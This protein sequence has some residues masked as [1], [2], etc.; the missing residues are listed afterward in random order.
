MV[1]LGDKKPWH[2]ESDW[3]FLAKYL[4][5]LDQNWLRFLAESR[6]TS[7]V[8]HDRRVGEKVAAADRILRTLGLT[9]ATE[10]TRLI[11]LVG[12][13]LFTA[14]CSTEDSVVLADISAALDAK[15]P[16]NFEFVA[17]NGRHMKAWSGISVD[18]A[19]DLDLF[20]SGAWFSG[21][22]LHSSYQAHFSSCTRSE[23]D[24]WVRSR[25]RG[26]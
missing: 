20:V 26:T 15:A 1:R 10:S 17:R 13:K 9:T 3:E 6:R 18:L 24:A 25:A 16:S 2:S 5:I 14:D 4:L 22:V 12:A 11:E 7:E 8:A 21:H 19:G 23:W